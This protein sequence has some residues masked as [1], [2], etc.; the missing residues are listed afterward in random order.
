MQKVKCG[1]RRL[2]AWEKWCQSEGRDSEGRNRCLT[3]GWECKSEQEN[4]PVIVES[5]EKEEE[6]E[7]EEEVINGHDSDQ[8]RIECDS[9]GLPS[10]VGRGGAR[11]KDMNGGEG[12][13][14]EDEGDL[15]IWNDEGKLLRGNAVDINT[16][17]EIDLLTGG[18][19]IGGK[20]DLTRDDM[21]RA[22]VDLLTGGDLMGGEVDLYN[23]LV[24]RS[25]GNLSNGGETD[26]LTGGDLLNGVGQIDLLA[27]GDV[28]ECEVELLTRSKDDVLGEDGVVVEEKESVEI[29]S[30]QECAPTHN[31]CGL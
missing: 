19:L 17:D 26:F 16:E 3:G 22:T 6:E 31:I 23:N 9:V 21:M 25:V 18:E 28:M 20:V 10:E 2:G 1:R 13:E 15:L 7:E 4:V 30:E 27:G 5:V 14:V 11:E 8:V 29:P 24:V 12:R